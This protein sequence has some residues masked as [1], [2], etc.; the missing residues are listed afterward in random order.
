M[1]QAVRYGLYVNTVG[2]QL[3][4]MEMSKVIHTQLWI[5]KCIKEFPRIT[6]D[7]RRRDKG[8]LATKE[9]IRAFLWYLVDN[10]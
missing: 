5:S 6:I 3:C 2:K 9:Y 4:G 7:G 1:S 10:L 8:L